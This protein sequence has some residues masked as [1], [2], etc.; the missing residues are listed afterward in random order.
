[1][2]RKEFMPHALHEFYRTV[3]WLLLQSRRAAPPSLVIFSS[4]PV[5]PAAGIHRAHQKAK[6]KH[7]VAFGLERR[8]D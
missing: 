3:F 8:V 7:G 1:M 5:Q 4:S 2:E 6:V